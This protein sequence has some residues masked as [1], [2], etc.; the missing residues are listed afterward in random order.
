MENMALVSAE[1]DLIADKSRRVIPTCFTAERS[2]RFS[3][4]VHSTI[5][6]KTNSPLHRTDFGIPDE[7]TILIVV[8][9]N[10]IHKWGDARNTGTK[11]RST[12]RCAVNVCCARLRTGT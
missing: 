8:E 1:P 9:V 12:V 10:R 11:P 7:D 4:P 2:G 3:D 5:G 6:R